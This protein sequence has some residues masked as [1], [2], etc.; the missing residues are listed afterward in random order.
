MTCEGYRGGGCKRYRLG[1]RRGDGY[2]FPRNPRQDLE[3]C[4][5]SCRN[6]IHIEWILLNLYDD[7]LQ[8]LQVTINNI[9]TIIPVIRNRRFI[10]F[11]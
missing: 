4:F 2:R 6:K 8:P 1:I 10:S 3:S 7:A 5:E 9:S 11:Y